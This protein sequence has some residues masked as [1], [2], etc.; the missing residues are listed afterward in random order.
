MKWD[1]PA[2][3]IT[4]GCHNPSKGRFLHPVAHRAITLREAALLQG[5]PPDYAFALDRGK[6]AAAAMIG[7]AVPPPLAAAQAAAIAR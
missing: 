2:P 3:T 5:F 6:L 4:G 7:N 1:R